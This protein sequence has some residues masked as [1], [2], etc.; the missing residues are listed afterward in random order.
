MLGP[1]PEF[2]TLYADGS[3]RSLAYHAACVE[4]EGYGRWTRIR[5][6][7]ELAGRM[8]YLHL[9]VAH[10]PDTDREA[11]LAASYLRRRG[12][13]VVLPDGADDC[14]PVGQ[15]DRFRKRATEFNVIAGMCVGHDALFIRHS[16]APVTSLVV[17]D[18]RLRH[19][20]VA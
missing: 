6:I 14:D 5:E 8:S 10:C 9:G 13:D 17:R 1:F 12:F 3:T 18:L 11:G 15:A 16:G 4:A 19:N 20:P 2:E 7:A